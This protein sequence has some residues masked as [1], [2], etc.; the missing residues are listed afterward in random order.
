MILMLKSK[1]TY[2]LIL[3]L[4][5][6]NVIN[7]QRATLSVSAE[8]EKLYGRLTKNLNDSVKLQINDSIKSMIESYIESDSVFYHRF[9]NLRYLGEVTSPDSTLKIVT[10]NL[11]LINKPGRYYSYFIKKQRN[12]KSNIIHRLTAEYNNG[13]IRNDTT[14]SADSWYGALYY[15]IRPQTINGRISWVLLGIDYGNQV[16]TRKIIDVL[17]Y[18]P[19]D[20]IIFGMKLFSSPDTLKYREIFEY[21][22]DAAMSLRFANDGSIVFDH[23]VPLSPELTIDRKYYVPHYSNDAYVNENGLWRY[24]INVDARNIQ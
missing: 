17:D 22:S 21:S 8:L 5:S 12:C 23:L 11:V 20:R 7:G 3:I 6:V 18:S 1:L 10:W 24:K 16:I 4:F 13:Q 2:L 14:Y 19:E 9:N 15:D